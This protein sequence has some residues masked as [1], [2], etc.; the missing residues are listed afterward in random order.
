MCRQQG[1]TS[2]QTIRRTCA[3]SHACV[4]CLRTIGYRHTETGKHH[5]FP[6]NNFKRSARTI[7]DIYKE[8]LQVDTFFRWIN[9]NLKIKAFIGN[10]R[11]DAMT[12]HHAALITLVQPFVFK[13]LAIIPASLQIHTRRGYQL[14]MLLFSSTYDRA[15]T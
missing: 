1:V 13:C 12:Q 8:R 15:N 6:I 10:A 2:D 9:Q 4:H 7:A 11:N 3:K 5:N 14:D